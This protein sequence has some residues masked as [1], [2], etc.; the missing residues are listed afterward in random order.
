MICPSQCII[1]RM[2]L[3]YS[4]TGDFNFCFLAPIKPPPTSCSI[5]WYCL[6][7]ISCTAIIVAK[8]WFSTSSVS[9]TF[10][11]S[12]VLQKSFPFLLLYAIIYS[13]IYFAIIK[14][15]IFSMNFNLSFSSFTWP[16]LPFG[17]L[18]SGSSV[19]LICPSL[20]KC[21]QAFWN[22]IL[23]TL[24]LFCPT[25]EVS[26]FFKESWCLLVGNGI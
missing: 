14:L 2:I 20:F 23:F 11:K 1:A 13:F 21:F 26:L 19:I 24:Y 8:L 12:L 4:I 15:I 7:G 16:I 22:K 18:Q 25:S 9:T 6:F 17:A 10:M 3:A 5:H